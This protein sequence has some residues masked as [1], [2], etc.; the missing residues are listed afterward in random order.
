MGEHDLVRRVAADLGVREIFWGV[1]VKPGKPL[2]FGA[3]DRTL[4]F[5][6]PGNPVSSLVGAIVFVTTALL[7]LQGASEQPP[8]LRLGRHLDDV[9][10]EPAPRRVRPRGPGRTTATLCGSSRSS[11]R[12]RT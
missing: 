1:A 10:S 6:L 11:D 9:S 3:R 4:V 8:P 7:A 2:S 5:G 12:S